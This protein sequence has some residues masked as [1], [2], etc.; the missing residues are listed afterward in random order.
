MKIAG[1]V[2]VYNMEKMMSK[3]VDS[4]LAQTYHEFELI[5]VDDGSKDS[6][7]Y[8]CDEYAKKDERVQVLHKENGGLMS[9]WMAG[10]E[11]TNADFCFFVDSDDWIEPDMLEKF[12]NALSGE[13]KEVICGNC[14]IEK[15]NKSIPQIQPCLP[16]KY[17]RYLIEQKIIPQILGNENRMLNFSRCT[18]LISR[19]LILDNLHYC[20]TA[21][22]M[23]EDVN[24]MLPVLLDAE[25]IV[26]LDRGLFY[27][28]VYVN[29]S[30]V[31]KYDSGMYKNILLL[32]DILQQIVNEKNIPNGNEMVNRE[33]LFLLFYVI[34][35][36][37]RNPDNEYKKRLQDILCTKDL[38][39]LVSS[40]VLEVNGHSNKIIYK[41]MK[42]PSKYIIIIGRLLISIFDKLTA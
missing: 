20:N 36:E 22:R 5:L 29:T 8:I 14:I 42:N 30:I 6:S 34:K 12:V 35:N 21:V 18:K 37:L 17:N 25:S 19:Q 31:H 26:V 32:Y 39:T 13:K 41:I 7:P 40:E 11:G 9:A 2:P 27:H 15:K 28:Y 23:A 24:I 16:G 4:I 3:C 1:I 10:V 38:K 33:Y